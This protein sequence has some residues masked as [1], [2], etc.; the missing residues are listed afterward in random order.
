MSSQAIG[1][2]SLHGSHQNVPTTSI[3][4]E[5]MLNSWIHFGYKPFADWI[6]R[7]DKGCLFRFTKQ[8]FLLS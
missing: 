8:G 2:I 3:L 5:V 4:S 1:I 6:E 7:N